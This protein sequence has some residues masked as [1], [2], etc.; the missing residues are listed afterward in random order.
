[1][2]IGFEKREKEMERDFEAKLKL[3]HQQGENN[4][5]QKSKSM[6]F[7]AP[8]EQFTINDFEL[9][10]IYGVGSYS[11]VKK[12]GKKKKKIGFCFWVLIYSVTRFG[13][14]D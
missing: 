1:M 3:Q 2:A 13:W 8:Q 4:T 9:G 10:K 11:K 12:N 5:V 7:R 6:N 14:W